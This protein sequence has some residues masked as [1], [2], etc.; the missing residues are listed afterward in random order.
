MDSYFIGRFIIQLLACVVV[1][2]IGVFNHARG[3][4][5]GPR[6]FIPYH[7]STLVTITL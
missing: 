2:V 1:G 6:T 5:T 4:D 3:K 7:G